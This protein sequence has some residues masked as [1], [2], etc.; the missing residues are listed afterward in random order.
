TSTFSST[1]PPCH[2]AAGSYRLVADPY[3]GSPADVGAVFIAANESRGCKPTGDSDF[4]SGPAT[5]TFTGTGEEIC[6]TLPTTAG[7]AVY[8]LNQ[9]AAGGNSPQLEVV[10]AT[11]AQIC[12]A[13]GDLFTNCALTGTAPFRII[14][15]GQSPGGGYRVLAQ[16]SDSTKGCAVWPQSGFG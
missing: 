2:L 7:P 1:A 12:Q 15:S 16:A 6:L 13:N 14:L 10:N 11:G 4:A 5:G 8:V 3:L 9:P